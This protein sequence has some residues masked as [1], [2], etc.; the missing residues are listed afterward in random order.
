MPTVNR[1]SVHP[2]KSLNPIDVDSAS[3]ARG[4]LA[5]D[6]KY[7]LF[8]ESDEYVS[9]KDNDR[10]YRLELAFDQDTETA[11]LS[12]RETGETREFHMDDDRAELEGW[13]TDFFEEDISIVQA[14]DTRFT[15]LAGGSIPMQISAP[16]PSVVSTA[17]YREIA[18]WFDDLSVEDI[19]R[20]FRANIEIGGVP[21]FWEDNLFSDKEHVVRFRIGDVTISGVVP[22]SR[23]S[24]PTK[25]PESGAKHDDFMETFVTNREEKFPDWANADH[26]GDHLPTRSQHYYYLTV[27]TRIPTSETGKTIHRGDDVSVLGEQAVV[28]SL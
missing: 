1:I 26:L 18:S 25:D 23:C 14:T 17:T 12:D 5:Y 24:V 16:G 27:V 21:P 9:G 15:G 3:I 2:I 28:K 7:A 10:V 8:D 19:R 11:T 13:L 22:L 20:R 4:G 6:R